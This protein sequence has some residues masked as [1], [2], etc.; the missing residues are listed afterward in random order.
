[1]TD[2]A[3]WFDPGFRSVEREVTARRLPVEGTIPE[4]VGGR[5]IRNGPGRFELGGERVN[6][7]FDGLA[8][9]R[10]YRIADGE[11][12]YTNRFLRSS[13]YRDAT[14]GEPTGQF[15]TH[16][17]GAR[18]VL[19]WLRRFGPPTPTDNA[20]VHVAR[21]DGDFV[22]L[23]EVPR[24]LRFDP[25]DLTTNGEFRFEDDVRLHTTTAHL[26]DDPHRSEHVGFG[27][28]FGARAAYH[29]FRIPDGSRRRE[30]IATVRTDSPAYVHSCAVTERHVV[31]PEPPLTVDRLGL[32]SP[33]TESFFDLLSWEP[34][35]GTRFVVVD[36]DRGTVVADPTVEPFFTLHTVNAFT[37]GDDVVVDLV[38][39]D[40]AGLLDA[41]SLDAL[42][43]RDEEP[44]DTTPTMSSGRCVRYR[45]GLQS[46]DV[47]RDRLCDRGVEFP[48]VVPGRRTRRHRYVFAQATDRPG[49]TG[50]CRLDVETGTTAEWWEHATFV[51]EPCVVT[52]NG[53]VD[54]EAVVL[55]PALDA[56]TERSLLLV[57][58]AATLTELARAPL[59]HH[60][61]FG[62][63]GRFFPDQSK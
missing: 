54:G 5:L 3:D 49:A 43:A 7:W 55:A 60:H 1:V 33:F 46:G 27:T 24:W 44:G 34:S 16:R 45:I 38:E 35:R 37:D 52:R 61:P 25:D 57:F 20:N 15:G 56:A 32:V 6:H 18:T 31:L 17:S 14:T 23:T 42:A 39:F 22:A 48:R 11:V 10:V 58:D 29:L 12:R 2:T 26:V 21:L 4:W 8:M 13:A 63:H 53:D 9:P 62:F 19:D 41:L 47:R 51:E 40:D 28:R 30:Q 50:L 59:P 36:R